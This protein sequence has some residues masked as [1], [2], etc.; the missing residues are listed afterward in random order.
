MCDF[1][2]SLFSLNG[3]PRLRTDA[4]SGTATG[5]SGSAEILE[6][7]EGHANCLE[8]HLT[9]IEQVGVHQYLAE[10]VKGS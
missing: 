1:V 6:D 7:T 5:K 3:M 2:T 8:W 9:L 10:P 4:G